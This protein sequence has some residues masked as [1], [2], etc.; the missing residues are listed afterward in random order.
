MAH[1]IIAEHKSKR[2]KEI[3]GPAKYQINKTLQNIQNTTNIHIAVNT[4]I[5]F[6]T[7]VFTYFQKI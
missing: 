4:I 6:I 7:R 5:I 3:N 1:I 2:M